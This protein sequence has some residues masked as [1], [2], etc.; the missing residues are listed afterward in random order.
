MQGVCIQRFC[1]KT[2]CCVSDGE[3]VSKENKGFMGMK[4]DPFTHKL[5]LLSFKLDDL[6]NALKTPNRRSQDII[7]RMPQH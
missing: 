7:F 2:K 3:D 1:E 5:Q 6:T 4:V